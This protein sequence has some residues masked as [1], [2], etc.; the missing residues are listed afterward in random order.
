MIQ[1]ETIPCRKCNGV[2]YIEQRKF[3]DGWVQ[4]GRCK[5]SGKLSTA[6]ARR[7]H[8]EVE[9]LLDL[10]W[11]IPIHEV[12][13]GNRIWTAWQGEA[14]AWWKVL[15]SYSVPVGKLWK[16]VCKEDTRPDK[17]LTLTYHENRAI[18]R[19]CKIPEDIMAKIAATP[20]VLV[21]DDDQNRG[22]SNA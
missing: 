14:P 5:G 8:V 21:V 9:K 22:K 1:Y 4:C 2:G 19:W 15:D 3:K 12:K 18:R 11:S 17:I 6:A 13:P 20:G 7:A 10:A 16:L